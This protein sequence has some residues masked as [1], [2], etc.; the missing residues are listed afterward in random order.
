[1]ATRFSEE[2]SDLRAG[3]ILNN[4]KAS[5]AWGIRILNEWAIGRATLVAADGIASLTTPLLEMSHVD[6][7]KCAIT[8]YCTHKS[9]I[10]GL[11]Y[12]F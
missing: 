10:S 9:T 2:V 6:L 11:L 4:K 3:A 7:Q 12:T 5:K 8:G 1:M